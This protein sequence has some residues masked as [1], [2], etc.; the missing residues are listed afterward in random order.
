MLLILTT[1]F[2][3]TTAHVCMTGQPL[4]TWLLPGIIAIKKAGRISPEGKTKFRLNRRYN[5]DAITYCVLPVIIHR[6]PALVS[7]RSTKERQGDPLMVTGSLPLLKTFC[8]PPMEKGFTTLKISYFTSSM[9]RP[10]STRPR[11]IPLAVALTLMI[12]P[13]SFWTT[14][15]FSPLMKVRPAREASL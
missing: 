6:R 14:T 7:L 13:F 11:P 4:G 10:P 9:V 15:P 5:A 12:T 2:S 3:S 1:K 8:M